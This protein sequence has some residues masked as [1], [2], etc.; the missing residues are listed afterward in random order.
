MSNLVNGR[1]ILKFNNSVLVQ[2]SSSSLH[3]N[4]LLNLYIVY[5][6]NN[7]PCNP[8]NSFLLK[9]RLFGTVGLVR[10]T[11]KNKFIYNG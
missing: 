6:L 2:K 8:T 10:N 7:G 9:I 3:S 11:I 5:E 1:V 4:F